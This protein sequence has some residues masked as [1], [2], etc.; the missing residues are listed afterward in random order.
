[1]SQMGLSLKID[2]NY[3]TIW[4]IEEEMIGAETRKHAPPRMRFK[5]TP[6]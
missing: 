3:K 1:M 4:P 2:G 6:L 5:A